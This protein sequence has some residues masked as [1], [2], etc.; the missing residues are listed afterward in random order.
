[1]SIWSGV[2]TRH[3]SHSIEVEV[4]ASSKEEAEKAIRENLEFGKYDQ[5]LMDTQWED[6]ENDEV[7][8]IKE[9]RNV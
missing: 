2:V 8:D 4:E 7:Y 6:G 3:V 5:R 1:M 9:E